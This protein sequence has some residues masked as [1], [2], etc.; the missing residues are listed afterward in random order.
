M[1]RST[2]T[3]N[4]KV[5]VTFDRQDMSEA[6]AA[7]NFAASLQKGE[8]IPIPDGVKAEVTSEK[9]KLVNHSD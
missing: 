2:L 6:G 4:L 9:P 5:V 7:V 1:K 8:L 3:V